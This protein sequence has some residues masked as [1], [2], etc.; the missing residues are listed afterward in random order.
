[1]AQ[2]TQDITIDAGRDACKTFRIT[3][4]DPEKGEWFAMRALMLIASS[5]NDMPDIGGGAMAALASSGIQNLFKC[6]PHKLKPLWDELTECWSF[7][8][9]K[10]K[11]F[12]RKLVEGDIEE[13]STRI[14]LRMKTLEM[15][16]N[17]FMVGIQ[18]LA[19]LAPSDR[20]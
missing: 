9:D 16:L 7:V 12:S 3:E 14:I 18:S 4:M 19:A 15:H 2:E 5:G 13:I 6:D 11:N 10:N 1:M 8:P 20:P 17:F